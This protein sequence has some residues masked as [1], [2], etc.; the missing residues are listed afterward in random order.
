[1]EIKLHLLPEKPYYS[2]NVLTFHRHRDGD[3]YHIA[4]TTYSAKYGLFNCHDFYLGDEAA[5]YEEFNEDIIAWCYKDE[6]NVAVARC[7]KNG[8]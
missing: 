4:D 5:E 3:I 1:M 8:K 7:L 2:C 6:V